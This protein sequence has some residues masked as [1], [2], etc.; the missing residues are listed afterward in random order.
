MCR[1]CVCVCDRLCASDG[2]CVSVLFHFGY[3]SLWF[4]DIER[5]LHAWS[6]NLLCNS[7]I[8]K[9]NRNPEIFGILYLGVLVLLACVCVSAMFMWVFRC[10]RL[11]QATPFI[12]VFCFAFSYVV[13]VITRTDFQT[14]IH[15]H[16]Q[17]SIALFSFRLLLGSCC[18]YF[19]TENGLNMCHPL[20][21]DDKQ[22]K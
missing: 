17:L 9:I 4:W 15:F 2:M 13:A 12:P 14:T 18:F 21:A 6:S 8:N 16:S 1:V 20:M 22:K 7:K 5:C 10:M 3:N 11:T 19:R